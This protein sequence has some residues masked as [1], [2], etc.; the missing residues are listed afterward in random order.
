MLFAVWE[1]N[2][3]TGF[4]YEGNRIK[5]ESD[6]NFIAEVESV[7]DEN[8]AIFQLPYVE[9]P[10]NGGSNN[11]NCLAHYIGFIHSDKLRWSFGVEEGT[12]SDIW[13]CSTASLPTAQMIQEVLNKGF[14]GIYINRDGYETADWKKLEAEIQSITGTEPIVSANSTL[15]FFK[16]R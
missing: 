9:Y 14:D 16:L 1:Q 10:E 3:G 5:W 8:D 7:M 13:Y 15:S 2:P 6:E 4:D 12:E 11:M